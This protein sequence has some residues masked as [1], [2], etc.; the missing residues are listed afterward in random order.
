[1]RHSLLLE[2]AN[3]TAAIAAAQGGSTFA[4]L[5]RD[6]ELID[7]VNG[8]PLSV[9]WKRLLD[10]KVSSVTGPK[11]IREHLDGLAAFD[12]PEVAAL[13]QFRESLAHLQAL[14][15]ERLQYL[16]QGTLDLASYRLDAWITSFATKRLTS[17]RASD[18]Q[19]TY[20]GGYGWVENLRP[21]PG[22]RTEVPAPAGETGPIFAYPDDSGFIHAPSMNHAAT[23]ALLRNAQLGA[24]GVPSESGPFSIDLSSRRVREAKWLLDGVR[25]GQQ[26]GALLGYRL[27]RRLHELRLDRFIHP[28]RELA[29]LSARKLQPSDRPLE[30]IAA[31][32]VVDG[33]VLNRKW[34]EDGRAVRAKLQNATEDELTKVS[35]ELD[36]LSDS[37]DAVSDALTAETAYQMVRGNNARLASTLNAL[38]SGDAP[39]PE[40]EVARTPRTGVALTHR[41]LQLFGGTTPAATGWA[42]TG[43]SARASAEPMLNAWAAKLLGDPREVRCTVERLDGSGSVLEAHSVLLSDLELTPLDVVYGVDVHP[44]RSKASEVEQRV[45][46][47]VRRRANPPPQQAQLRI[48]H[49]R[50][51]D[52]APT[53][54]TLLDVIEQ[55]RRLRRLLT[56]ARAADP[57]DLTPTE[58]GESG[59][60]NLPELNERVSAAEN[61]LKAAHE[62]L[63]ALVKNGAA[64]DAD[65]LRATLLKLGRFGFQ[66]GLPV[67]AAGD[68]A[69]TR[70]ALNMQGVALLKESTARIEEVDALIAAPAQ[71]EG[72]ARRDRL[73]ERMRTVFGSDFVAMPLF[74]CAHAVELKSALAASTKVQGGDP[75]VVHT[76]FTRC[77]RVRDPAARLSA[78]MCGA[79]VLGSTERLGLRVAQLPFDGEDR[80]VGLPAEEGKSVQAGKLSLVVQSASDVDVEEPLCGLLVDEWVE[81]VPSAAETT[82]I[83]FQFNP[84]DACAPQSVL[85]AVPPIPDQPWTVASLHR[86]LVE[87]LDLAKLRAVDAEALWE[88]AH[89]LPATFLAFNANDEVPSTDFAELTRLP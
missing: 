44:N 69:T 74:T 2:Y 68:D 37:I 81:V 62:T 35:R 65:A 43:T 8:E 84:P 32:N 10:V 89:Y 73:L 72:R 40:L 39:A 38:A 28:L 58:R 49:A 78:L 83:A 31:N 7:L 15:S 23:A 42:P 57:E 25:H 53:Q 13:G 4:Q 27:E 48:Q 21:A 24:T 85:L 50:Q 82:A 51:A 46:Y 41:V 6:R 75:L 14:D 56:T 80:W 63:D 54:L 3:A 87:T 61:A 11:T 9:T 20:I 18:A 70:A 36:G 17:M 26:L 76:W 52:L 16:M 86:V 5:L 34:R 1:M 79:E 60:V 19:G 88:V 30:T 29:P 64:A 22:S 77:A 59:A 45:L 47:H 66:A 12:T 55:A 71:A 67:I 33:L